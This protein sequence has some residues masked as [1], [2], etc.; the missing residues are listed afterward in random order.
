[1]VD[2]MNCAINILFY[3]RRYFFSGVRAGFTLQSFVQK[4]RQKRISAPIPDAGSC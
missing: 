4:G 3:K 1:M 2:F